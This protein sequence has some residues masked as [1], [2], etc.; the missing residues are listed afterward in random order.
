ML[1]SS[2]LFWLL[3]GMGGGSNGLVGAFG[4]RDGWV[5]GRMGEGYTAYT[6]LIDTCD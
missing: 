1:F 4:R 3:E 2:S 5:D 6:D